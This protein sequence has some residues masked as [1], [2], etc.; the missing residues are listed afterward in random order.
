M[1]PLIMTRT[2]QLPLQM[3]PNY[4]TPSPAPKVLPLTLSQILILF[5]YDL[6]A[7]HISLK[8]TQNTV[9]QTSGPIVDILL[10]RQTGILV[11]SEIQCISALAPLP[12]YT[13]LILFL[14]A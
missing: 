4:S 11:N 14:P 7:L 8:K 10:S 5:R 2:L 1:K 6:K 12:I 13:S 3:A 9:N